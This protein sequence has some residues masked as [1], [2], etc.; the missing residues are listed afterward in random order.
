MRNNKFNT[1]QNQLGYDIIWTFTGDNN[2]NNTYDGIDRNTIET[3]NHHKKTT[4][5]EEMISTDDYS[6]DEKYL[7]NVSEKILVRVN[8][9]EQ[10]RKINRENLK[11]RRK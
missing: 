6:E 2:N 7:D 3:R 5:Y 4:S 9:Q 10:A 8:R 1:Q 11:L